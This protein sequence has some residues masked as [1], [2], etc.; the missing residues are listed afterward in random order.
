MCRG[1]ALDRRRR[2]NLRGTGRNFCA[3]LRWQGR[4]RRRCCGHHTRCNSRFDRICRGYG[5]TGPRGSSV[6]GSLCQQLSRH[7]RSGN[8]GLRHYAGGSCRLNLGGDRYSRLGRTGVSGNFCQQWGRHCR[9]R[10]H[11]LS[12]HVNRN[13]RLHRIGDRCCSRLGRTGVSGNLRQQ[14]GRHCRPRRHVLNHYV[15]RNNRVNRRWGRGLRCNGLG[16]TLC[17]QRCGQCGPR[18]RGVSNCVRRNNRPNRSPRRR[19][20]CRGLGA[21]CLRRCGQRGPRLRGLGICV[22]R[23]K[24]LNISRRRG[25]DSR[26]TRLNLRGHSCLAL[27]VSQ[28]QLQWKPVAIEP[29]WQ[30]HGSYFFWSLTDFS[31]ARKLIAFPSRCNGNCVFFMHPIFSESFRKIPTNLI[32]YALR[33]IFI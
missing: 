27:G 26:A 20:R 1:L 22:C 23:N 10:R 30:G 6:N 33:R 8:C 2:S 15:R 9:P 28:I 12:H 13:R 4:S 24:R 3:Q 21:L 7:C 29:P 18:H 16:D 32:Q 17:G 14:W 11:G 19:L 5:C 25:L 31:F